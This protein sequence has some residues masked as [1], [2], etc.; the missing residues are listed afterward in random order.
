MH[1]AVRMICSQIFPKSGLQIKQ[2]SPILAKIQG[3]KCSMQCFQ[4][5]LLPSLPIALALCVNER[6]AL[7]ETLILIKKAL[8][9]IMP[10]IMYFE[11]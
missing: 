11:C 3:R 5:I 2:K 6:A 9:D 10:F 8:K 7:L 1:L 4:S